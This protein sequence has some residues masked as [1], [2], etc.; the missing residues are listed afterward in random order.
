MP[1]V[2]IG[3]GIGLIFALIWF[4]LQILPWLIGGGF[5][6]LVVAGIHA[7]YTRNNKGT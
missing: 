1:Y 5:L 6:L 7:L 2:F 3:I 4:F